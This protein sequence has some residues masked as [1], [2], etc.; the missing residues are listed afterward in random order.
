MSTSNKDRR[1]RVYWT[2]LT[3]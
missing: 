3:T 2:K 1:E